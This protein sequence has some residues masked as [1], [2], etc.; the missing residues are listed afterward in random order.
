MSS[1]PVPARVPEGQP[2]IRVVPEP[3]VETTKTPKFVIKVVGQI[4]F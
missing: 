2:E 4:P 3:K 1:N